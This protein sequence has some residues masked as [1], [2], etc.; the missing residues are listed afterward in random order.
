[1]GTREERE[2]EDGGKGQDNETLLIYGAGCQKKMSPVTEWKMENVSF[3]KSRPNVLI[4][5][6]VLQT[7]GEISYRAL[8]L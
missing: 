6:V 5:H 3:P 1:M 4:V 7:A 8:L 2:A